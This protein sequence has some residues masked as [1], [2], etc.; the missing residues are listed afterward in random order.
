MPK[1]VES[2][3]PES[4][5]FR[6]APEDWRFGTLVE[7]RRVKRL[8][9]GP[10]YEE[11]LSRIAKRGKV[12]FHKRER[13]RDKPSFF[14]V[15]VRLKVDGTAIDLFHNSVS[16]YRAQYF[17]N[18]ELGERANLAALA[19]LAPIAVNAA[20][21]LPKRTC[22][23]WWVEKSLLDSSAK[24]WVHQG[25]WMRHA[26]AEDHQL[27]V[28]RWLKQRASP[29]SSRSKKAIWSSLVPGNESQLELKGGFLTLEGEPLGS[30]KA[31]RARDLHE[32]GFT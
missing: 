25:L 8:H 29:D 11:I 24:V 10:S 19:Q 21:E 9:S 15:V 14:R 5:F 16:G 18:A 13:A 4:K 1:A 28:D 20:M 32:L 30:L 12:L 3:S 23:A 27:F 2:R 31:S 22:P 6:A 7:G 26:K 17:H